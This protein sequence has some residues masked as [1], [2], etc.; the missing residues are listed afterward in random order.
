MVLCVCGRCVCAR[1]R[2]EGWGGS[3]CCAG[4]LG[5]TMGLADTAELGAGARWILWK[6][7]GWDRVSWEGWQ[8]R[9]ESAVGRAGSRVMDKHARRLALLEAG[10]EPRNTGS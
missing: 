6:W 7:V 9:A 4:Q 3:F 1:V 5:G 10:G 2:D 8:L